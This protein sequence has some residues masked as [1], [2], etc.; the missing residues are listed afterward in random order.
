M[1]TKP[2]LGALAALLIALGGA[3]LWGASGHRDLDWAP[4]HPSCKTICTRPTSPC[5][6][7][8][9]IWMKA[10]F[11]LRVDS[12]RQRGACCAGPESEASGSDGGT[13]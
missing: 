9:W 12:S 6:A 10:T 5:S 3:W 7:L 1:R 13:R 2:V 11:L 4:G 8:V